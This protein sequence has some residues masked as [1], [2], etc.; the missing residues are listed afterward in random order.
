MQHMSFMLTLVN[1]SFDYKPSA[2]LYLI[3][4]LT[5][6]GLILDKPVFSQGQLYV[7]LSRAKNDSAIRVKIFQMTLQDVICGK[8]VTHNV[9]F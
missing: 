7:A 6:I 1:T 3:I 8:S 2:K 4:T 9:V 5:E